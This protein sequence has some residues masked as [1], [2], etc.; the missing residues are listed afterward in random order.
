MFLN[1]WRRDLWTGSLSQS[2]R[3]S[4]E[5]ATPVLTF[6]SIWMAS[7]NTWLS[8][9]ILPGNTGTAWMLHNNGSV[10]CT[11]RMHSSIFFI[12]SWLFSPSLSV[13][14]SLHLSLSLNLPPLAGR[15]VE[16]KLSAWWIPPPTCWL[17]PIPDENWKYVANTCRE[18]YG[19]LYTRG[20]TSIDLQTH[21]NKLESNCKHINIG[22]YRGAKLRGGVCTFSKLHLIV[23]WGNECS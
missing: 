8:D 6:A 13:S 20:T 7:S 14:L 1:S 16:S 5:L 10:R 9:V 2:T 23:F 3:S 4:R 22:L 17:I 21:E 12:R 18:N 15:E 19:K 11:F